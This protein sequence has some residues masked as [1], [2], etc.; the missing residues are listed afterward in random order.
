MEPGSQYL[1]IVFDQSTT[2]KENLFLP[3]ENDSMLSVILN[4]A[5]L[6]ASD[7]TIKDPSIVS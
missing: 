1:C 7:R 4:K 6:L 2:A 5:F 3:F